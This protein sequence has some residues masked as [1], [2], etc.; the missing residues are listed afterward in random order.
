MP[1][2]AAQIAQVQY[3]HLSTSRAA[4][5]LGG[6]SVP[7]MTTAWFEAIVTPPLAIYRVLV[8][9]DE[10]ARVVGFAAIGP[11]DDPDAEETDALVAEFCIHPDELDRGDEDRLLHACVDT[12]RADGFELAAWWLD[13]TDDATRRVLTESG[14]AADGAHREIG[15]EDG[16]VRI[17]QIRMRTALV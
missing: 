17:K 4:A 15:D 11:S 12:L 7:E 5:A 9:L 14:W 8:A 2:E 10:A 6:L 16:L 3:A 13:A 1:A